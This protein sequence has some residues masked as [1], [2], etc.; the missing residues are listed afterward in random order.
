MNSTKLPGTRLALLIKR[1][2]RRTWPAV[3]HNQRDRILLLAEQSHE[4]Y[5]MDILFSF[6]LYRNFGHELRERIHPLLLSSPI[7]GELDV[8]R[9]SYATTMSRQLTSQSSS[10]MFA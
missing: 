6:D 2:E 1:K 10:P 5:V 8:G 3:K 4:M 9:G 7:S